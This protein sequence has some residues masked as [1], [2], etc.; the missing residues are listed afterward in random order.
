[1]D[2]NIRH[3]IGWITAAALKLDMQHERP[4]IGQR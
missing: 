2:Y 4:T 3:S 1:M